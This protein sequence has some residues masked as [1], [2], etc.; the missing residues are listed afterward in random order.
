MI[1]SPLRWAG[2]KANVMPELNKYLK[3]SERLVDLF[4][5]GGTVFLNTNYTRYTL[6][7]SNFM[8]MNFYHELTVNTEV[9]IERAKFLFDNYGDESSYYAY[10][11][12]YHRLCA[13]LETSGEGDET[14]AALLF[15]YINRHCYGGVYRCN[16]KGEFNMAYSKVGKARF[17][18][19]ELRL[20][21][22]K[23]N[24]THATFL[25]GDFRQA[26]S[27]VTGWLFTQHEA[28]TIYADPPY[29]PLEGKRNFNKYGGKAF[30][31]ADH[32]E[33]NNILIGTAE[34]FGSQIVL[35]NSDTKDTREAYAG[36][37]FYP[38]ETL[39]KLAPKTR[40]KVKELIGIPLPF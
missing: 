18:E 22:E 7:D 34:Y 23:A 27:V 38:V 40:E 37:E 2:S 4:V 29:F 12:E 31:K 19:K 35:S 30:E 13:S 28:L 32:E 14:A 36:F 6:C 8:L 3:P 5:G 1:K 16:E 26:L 10:R 15:L 25:V 9:Y 33:L 39:R 24:D 11:K 20:F 21:A 17:P